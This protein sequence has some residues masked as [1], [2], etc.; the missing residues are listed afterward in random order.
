MRFPSLTDLIDLNSVEIKQHVLWPSQLRASTWKI[1][2]KRKQ[3]LTENRNKGLK[4]G[5][6]FYSYLF[7]LTQ[8]Y[9]IVHRLLCMQNFILKKWLFKKQG[10]LRGLVNL[11]GSPGLVLV[12]FT[13]L[14]GKMPGNYLEFKYLLQICPATS[15]S[16][17]FL[18]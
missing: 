15:T 2:S 4:E 16:N 7:V 12:F 1:D 6:R 18:Q 17:H 13:S 5:K 8:N 3:T 10:L 9:I 11:G 14:N